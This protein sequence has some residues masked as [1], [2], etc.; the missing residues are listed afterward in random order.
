MYNFYINSISLKYRQTLLQR[1]Q[2]SADFYHFLDDLIA[3]L[4]GKLLEFLSLVFLNTT[5]LWLKPVVPAL[6]EAE[7]GGSRGQEIETTLA[8]MVKPHLC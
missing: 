8:N 4:F 3:F 5:I 7:T 2:R 1:I 6:W